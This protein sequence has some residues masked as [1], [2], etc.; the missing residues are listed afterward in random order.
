MFKTPSL[1]AQHLNQ[2]SGFSVIPF[3]RT[4][5]PESKPAQEKTFALRTA[6]LSLA[7]Y[8]KAQRAN[9]RTGATAHPQ[10]LPKRKKHSHFAIRP[11]HLSFPIRPSSLGVV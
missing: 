6:H 7:S 11:S 1:E 4:R 10:A 2:S 8:K 3:Y 5:S 9:T